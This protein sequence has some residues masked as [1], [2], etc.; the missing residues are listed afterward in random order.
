MRFYASFISTPKNLE[1]G[2]FIIAFAMQIIDQ[3][4]IPDPP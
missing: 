3:I 2:K 4:D 1:H